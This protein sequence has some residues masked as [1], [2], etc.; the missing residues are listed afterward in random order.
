[1]FPFDPVTTGTMLILAGAA[2]KI[3]QIPQ[4]A[5]ISVV[6]KAQQLVI[7]TSR[8]SAE[9]Q[10]QK[11]D[12][13]N[14]YGYNSV[15]HTNGFMEGRIGMRSEV[16]LDYKQAPTKKRAYC[17]WY[18][19]VTIELEIDPKIVIAKEV[20]QDRCMYNAVLEHEMKHINVDRKIVNKYAKTIGQKVFQGLKQRGFIA[21]P[22]G[23]EYAQSVI[24]RMKSTVNQLIELENKKMEIERSEAQQAVDS[25]EE[26][27]Y[28]QSKCPNYKPPAS[29]SRSRKRN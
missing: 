29:A 24:D 3:C 1:M 28:V 18:E 6:P 10:G 27:E 7:D 22:I 16:K 2:P 4:P 14:P 13:I 20:A 25:L 21:G 9:I 5:E 26:Y 15:T 17:V 8:T 11:I 23:P 12:T 19:S